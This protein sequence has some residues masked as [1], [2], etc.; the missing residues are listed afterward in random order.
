LIDSENIDLI[1]DFMMEP[2][3]NSQDIAGSQSTFR[4]DFYD[5]GYFS[6]QSTVNSCESYDMPASQSDDSSVI[7]TLEQLLPLCSYQENHQTVGTPDPS[8][9]HCSSV[10]EIPVSSEMANTPDPSAARCSSVEEIPISSEMAIAAPV[11]QV[12]QPPI[13]FYTLKVLDQ[14]D[15]F[16]NFSAGFAVNIPPGPGTKGAPWAVS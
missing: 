4:D 10:E 16:D 7:D 12:Q 8:A 13:L 11:Q 3:Y 5:E 6:V 9:A 2:S 14:S 15:A 1:P